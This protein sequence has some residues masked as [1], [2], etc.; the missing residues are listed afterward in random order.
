MRG[1]EYAKGEKALPPPNRAI[2]SQHVS[3]RSERL[4]LGLDSEGAASRGTKTSR[5]IR[6][7]LSF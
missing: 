7:H 3:P 1:A 6:K 4:R 5:W 2:T